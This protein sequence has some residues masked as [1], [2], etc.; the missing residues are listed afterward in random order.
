VSEIDDYIRAN[1]ERFSR[2]A[3]DEKLRAAGH[4]DAAIEAAWARAAAGDGAAGVPP[5]TPLVIL[6]RL[7]LIG[8]IAAAYGYVGFIGLIGVGFSLSYNQTP[9]GVVSALQTLLVAAY[10]LAMLASFL[11]VAWRVW[12]AGTP[13]RRGSTTAGAVGVAFVLLVGVSG[14]CFALTILAGA[15]ISCL[16]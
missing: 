3:L 9:T 2:Q 4:D 6:G 1:R 7:V 12:R 16:G 8:L 10:G 11:Y 13:G 5:R 15:F 14:A